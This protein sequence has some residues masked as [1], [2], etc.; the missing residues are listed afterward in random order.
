M[1]KHNF[2][3]QINRKDR[4]HM[5]A[6]KKASEIIHQ[7]TEEANAKKDALQAEDKLGEAG[8]TVRPNT[9]EYE[10]S[11]RNKTQTERAI[12]DRGQIAIVRLQRLL[13][14]RAAQNDMFRGKEMR[15]D[16]I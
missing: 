5:E 2:K 1:C 3:K 14:G 10:F 7:K 9:P 4:A 16:L 11:D 8:A 6:L 12:S 15:L 13:R